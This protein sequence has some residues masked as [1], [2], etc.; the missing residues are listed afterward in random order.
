LHPSLLSAV[1]MKRPPSG[2]RD[3]MEVELGTQLKPDKETSPSA[4][5]DDSKI[6]GHSG[7]QDLNSVTV[8]RS[9]LLGKMSAVTS[10]VIFLYSAAFWIQVGAMPVSVKRYIAVCR[11]IHIR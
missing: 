11:F 5:E 2:A 9:P 6:D 7:G 1:A 10:T 8:E 3:A 4:G